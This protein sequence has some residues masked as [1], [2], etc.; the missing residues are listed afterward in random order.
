MISREN[1]HLWTVRPWPTYDGRNVGADVKQLK[2]IPLFFSRGID[3]SRIF[4]FL[5]HRIERERVVK[6]VKERKSNAS[7]ELTLD[8]S[9]NI[10]DPAP[11]GFSASD[12]RGS[13]M[14][15]RKGSSG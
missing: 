10:N 15:E 3:C 12:V 11:G 7:N 14:Y 8:C 1:V 9:L 2:G 13:T 6:L 5:G 4:C